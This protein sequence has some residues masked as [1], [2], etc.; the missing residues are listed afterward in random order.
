MWKFKSLRYSNLCNDG[1]MCGLCV[2]VDKSHLT[3]YAPVH[4][5]SRSW[6]VS[7]YVQNQNTCKL[8]KQDINDAVEAHCF[9]IDIG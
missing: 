7:L 9:V 1:Q 4:A 2:M 6:G 8:P 3:Q 5:V